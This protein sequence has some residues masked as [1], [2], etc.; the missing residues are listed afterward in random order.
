MLFRSGSPEISSQADLGLFENIKKKLGDLVVAEEE[1]AKSWYKTGRPD[2]P[3]VSNVDPG[4]VLPLSR[5]SHVV[6]N[7]KA[8]NRVLL[9]VRPDQSEKA[10]EM[11]RGV[12]EHERN[13][14]GT[15]GFDSGTS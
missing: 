8:N 12:L 6:L 7:M 3:V 13:Q 10:N 11:V 5:Y 14:Q 15:F 1:S 2:I 9:Y 4:T